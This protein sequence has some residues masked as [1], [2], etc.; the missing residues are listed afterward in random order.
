M[1]TINISYSASQTT[2][3][4]RSGLL[5]GRM[6]FDEISTLSATKVKLEPGQDHT[7]T[8]EQV[9]CGDVSI[10]IL[11]QIENE[12]QFLSFTPSKEFS[13]L[14]LPFRGRVIFSNPADN[15]IILPAIISYIA[16]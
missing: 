3:R 14:L 7:V 8:F 12:I 10:P 5:Q 6:T 13:S 15:S 1:S 9:F 11:I 16:I 4:N 2:G